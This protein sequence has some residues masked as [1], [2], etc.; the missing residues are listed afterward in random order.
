M[1]HTFRTVND[2]DKIWFIQGE[3]ENQWTLLNNTKKTSLFSLLTN[4]KK[5]TETEFVFID[6]NLVTYKDKTEMYKMIRTPCGVICEVNIKSGKKKM[7]FGISSLN[8]NLP[9]HKGAKN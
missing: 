5:S 9:K 1:K 4:E 2:F 7:L 6:N 8:V 3:Q